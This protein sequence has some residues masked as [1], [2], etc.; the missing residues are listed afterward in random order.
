MVDYTTYIPK[1]LFLSEVTDLQVLI[2]FAII[3][4]V[5]FLIYKFYESTSS[6]RKPESF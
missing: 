5:I 1:E 3:L 6:K 4:V 2:G